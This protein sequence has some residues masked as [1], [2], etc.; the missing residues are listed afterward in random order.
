[1]SKNTGVTA[2]SAGKSQFVKTALRELAKCTELQNKW[3]TGEVWIAIMKDRFTIPPII[4]IT[5]TDLNVATARDPVMKV[6]LREYSVPNILCV[7]KADYDKLPKY[8]H[9]PSFA[10]A[11]TS[12]TTRA[13]RR[14]LRNTLRSKS[15]MVQT[16]GSCQ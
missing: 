9:K 1:M 6:C 14:F 4:T 11:P 3:M 7:Y 13:A 5:T 16:F 15:C 10:S 8:P 2:A 12:R